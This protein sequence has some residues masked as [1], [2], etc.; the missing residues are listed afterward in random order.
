[1]EFLAAI[2]NGHSPK[3]AARLLRVRVHTLYESR[4]LLR[5][6]LSADNDAQLVVNA[7]AHGFLDLNIS[8]D[9]RD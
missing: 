1:M 3:T 5:A 8:L 4:R 7:V 9:G 2:A 6:R